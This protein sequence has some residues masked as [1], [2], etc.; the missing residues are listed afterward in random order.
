MTEHKPEPRDEAVLITGWVDPTIKA[1]AVLLAKEGGHP[2]E[3]WPFYYAV[4]KA[5]QKDKP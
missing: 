5:K 1:A 4:A 3:S 2:E